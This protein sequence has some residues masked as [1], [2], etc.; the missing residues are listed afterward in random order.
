MRFVTLVSLSLTLG[1]VS[2]VATAESYIVLFKQSEIGITSLGHEAY[3]TLLQSGNQKSVD[4]LKEWLG[5]K[6]RAA[7]KI[8]DLWLVR[9]AA[10]QLDAQQSKELEKEP[11]VGGVY[12]DQKRRFVPETPARVGRRAVSP[13]GLDRIGLPKIRKEFPK[14]DGTGV[15]V[16]ILDTGIQSRHP[17]F[18]RVTAQGAPSQFIPVNFKDFINGLLNPY[19][20][21]GHGTHVAGTI[22]GLNV[23]IAPNVELTVAK[24]FTANGM[25]QDSTLLAAM[26][27]VFDPDG[28]P[29]TADFVQVVSNSWGADLPE[30]IAHDMA[31]FEPYRLAVQS[32]VVGGVVPVFAAGNS[33]GMPNGIPGG[34]PE[35]LAV[36]ALDTTDLIAD[37][38]S[39]GPNLWRVGQWVLTLLKPDVSAPGV[40]TYSAFPGNEYA[41]MS[42]TSMATPHVSGAV[43]L[44][45]QANHKLKYGQLKEAIAASSERKLDVSFGYG[46]LNAYELVKLVQAR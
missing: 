45:L 23:G 33:G 9:G 42:G 12:V 3:Q 40:D 4:Q 5:R 16:G 26:Q 7:T 41:S 29:K 30:A 1:V 31:M 46:V 38:S 20:D 15:R 10:V 25:G 36:G 24:V 34:L 27:W 37:F 28:N 44:A 22:A 13:W 39:R 11:W 35:A 32:W 21:H 19:D 43:A 8:S 17:E 18:R 6:G 14:L 2:R